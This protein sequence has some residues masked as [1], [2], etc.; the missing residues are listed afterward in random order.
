MQ[1]NRPMD[2][3]NASIEHLWEELLSRYPKRIWEAFATLNLDQQQAVLEHLER[4]VKETGWQPEQRKSA[5][6]ALDAIAISKD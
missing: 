2:E 5:Q 1:Y 3:P 6:A 4:M